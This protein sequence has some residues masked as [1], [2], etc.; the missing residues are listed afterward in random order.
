MGTARALTSSPAAPPLPSM[1][2]TRITKRRRIDS[3]EPLIL[4]DPPEAH[5]VA[6]YAVIPAIC[7]NPQCLCTDM[8]FTIHHVQQLGD[9]SSEIQQSAA[10]GEVSSDGTGVK[11][12]T[13]AGTLTTETITWIRQRLEQDNPR[14]WFHERWSRV[15]GQA[16]DPAYPS[17]AA[18]E[19]IDGMVFFSEVFPY[20]FDLTVVHERC[21][22]LADDQYCLKPACTCDEFATHFVDLSNQSP[23][24]QA[25]GHARTSARHLQAPNVHGPSLVGRLWRALPDSHGA[26]RLRDRFQRMRSV[27]RARAAATPR[28]PSPMSSRRQRPQSVATRSARCLFSGKKLGPVRMLRRCN[29]A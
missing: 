26:D 20:E 19:R 18:P 22:Y 7:T 23:G 15:C 3:G 4:W 21:V 13:A 29:G 1:V 28:V 8:G 25:I 6:G 27:A 12:D 10:A 16:G 9:G 17:E 2:G 5:G 24:A 11:I 14:A